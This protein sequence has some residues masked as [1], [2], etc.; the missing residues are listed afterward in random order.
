MFILWQ[1]LNVNY[2]FYATAY[3]ECGIGAW[4]DNIQGVEG[5]L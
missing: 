5:D 2:I 1:I 3:P 4:S